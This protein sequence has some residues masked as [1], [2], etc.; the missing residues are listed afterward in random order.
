MASPEN[1]PYVEVPPEARE[2]RFHVARYFLVHKPAHEMDEILV[3]HG[4]PPGVYDPVMTPAEVKKLLWNKAEADGEGYFTFYP[5]VM[6]LG[7]TAES[8]RIP[9]DR[10]LRMRER[11]V[12][13][14]TSQELP[15][16]TNWGA[17]GLHA[18][19]TGPQ[20]YE[21]LNMS[22]FPLRVKVSDLICV[23]DVFRLTGEISLRSNTGGFREQT[24]G[25]ILVVGPDDEETIAI[26]RA[27]I[28]SR[29]Q[30]NS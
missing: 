2:F 23:A 25:E 6:V 3:A 22:E 16:T 17:P 30:R 8:I 20:T 4:L 21:I 10:T 9:L 15:L 27:V 1:R 7:H 26:R 29:E 19:S 28:A 24:V 18:G 14:E 13:K 12:S 11:F 5:G